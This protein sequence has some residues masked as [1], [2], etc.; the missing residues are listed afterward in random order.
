MS[1]ICSEHYI[2]LKNTETINFY[3]SHPFIDY[4]KANQLLVDLFKNCISTENIQESHKIDLLYNNNTNSNIIQNMN[5]N[6]IPKIEPKLEVILNKLNP[7]SD[8]INN[9]D[10]TICGDYIIITPNKANIIIE[11][12]T[13]EINIKPCVV[14]L[15]ISSCKKQKANGILLSQHTG[16]TG[17]QNFEIDIIDSNV[18]IYIHS[19]EYDESKIQ[20][21]FEIINK[22]YEKIKLINTDNDISISKDVLFEIKNE[23][24]T[25]VNKKEEI[26]NNIKFSQNQLMHQLENIKLDNLNDYLSTKFTQIEKKYQHKCNLCNFYTSNTLKG[27]A[28]HKRGCKKKF[29]NVG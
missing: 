9:T 10:E 26:Q 15:F 16:I 6:Y 3:E 17:K 8:I 11:N 2:K 18:I 27:M 1:E 19:V 5:D 12:K 22:I 20:M 7:S 28:A 21:A 24:Q 25:F 14:S 13:N 29:A 23:Y 4:E